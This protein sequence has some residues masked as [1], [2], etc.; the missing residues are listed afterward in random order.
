MSIL[1]K[2]WMFQ[3]GSIQVDRNNIEKDGKAESCHVPICC[4]LILHKDAG[5]ILI[6]A[7]FGL[8]MLNR[9]KNPFF[10]LISKMMRLNYKVGMD[11]ASRVEACGFTPSGVK[12]AVLTH[13]HYDHTGGIMDFPEAEFWVHMDEL[14][15]GRDRPGLRGY[16]KSYIESDYR[17]APSLVEYQYV[18]GAGVGPFDSGFDL[19]GDGTIRLLPTP[20][21]TPGHT[22][23]FLTMSDG[24]Q[25]LIV[26]DTVF[27]EPQI[28]KGV[29][30]GKMPLKFT[31]D[32]EENSISM[33][34]IRQLYQTTP[35]LKL[36]L[37]H[38]PEQG[39]MCVD[40]P[41]CLYG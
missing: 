16:N 36:L 37:T 4:Y 15:A 14:S 8:S 28:T 11:C 38:D 40:G 29:G 41:V 25:F 5:P 12:K 13:L 19:M 7:G 9:L 1:N 23:V 39:E 10:M 2:L 32:A 30:L 6:D 33:E 26:G 17:D 22:S 24:S 18:S 34:K 20:G 21:H 31:R 35:S 27:T 3:T